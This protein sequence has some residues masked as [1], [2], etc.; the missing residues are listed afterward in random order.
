[1][2]IKANID[3]SRLNNAIALADQKM[4]VR[5]MELVEAAGLF[6]TQSFAK[7]M[8][9]S[10]K[11]RRTYTF[12]DTSRRFRAGFRTSHVI[13]RRGGGKFYARRKND[14]REFRTIEYQGLGR[15]SIIEAARMA[16]LAPAR[17]KGV[18]S[19]ATQAA[20]QYSV[21]SFTRDTRRPVV[22]FSYSARDVAGYPGRGATRRAMHLAS[23][24]VLGYANRIA[25]EQRQ[26][27]K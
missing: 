9:K 7:A 20:A 4:A 2:R 1:M 6:F 27:F 24:R 12:E 16:G 23:K 10:R 3:T 11:K 17:P 14:L 26:A 19:G 18:G 5:P 13:Y 21:G 15:Q 22:Q 25:R 8:P